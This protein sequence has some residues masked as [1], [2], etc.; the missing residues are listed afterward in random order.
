MRLDDRCPC[1]A[2]KLP[3]CRIG[4]V[5]RDDVPIEAVEATQW[6]ALAA[7]QPLA[8]HAFL[9]ALHATGCAST[10]TG[11]QPRY[12][13]AWRGASLAGAMP[14][15]AKAHSYGEY[16]FD[17]AWADAFRRHGHRYYPK[18]VCAIPFTPTTGARLF[19]RS[20]DVRAALLAHALA[21]DRARV[22]RRP[23]RF[24]RCTSCFP[25]PPTPRCAGVPA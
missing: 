2:K 24:R 12:L 13:T 18:L 11:W 8:S 4:L 14:V 23:P 21:T 20:D 7:G 6:N 3:N 16:V 9:T 25:T 22:G 1:H 5:I 15:Y 17:W 19:A 10:A